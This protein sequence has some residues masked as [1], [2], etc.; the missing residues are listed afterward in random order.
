VS[1]NADPQNSHESKSGPTETTAVDCKPEDYDSEGPSETVLKRREE[2][3]ALQARAKQRREDYDRI[4]GPLPVRASP[5]REYP[6]EEG[7]IK[8]NRQ[9]KRR[10]AMLMLLNA[11][12]AAFDS[13]NN[14]GGAHISLIHA[15]MT[16]TTLTNQVP[17]LPTKSYRMPHQMMVIGSDRECSSPTSDI[18]NSSQV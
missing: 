15:S 9:P 17:Q 8:W 5:P 18:A 10:A 2:F 16:T 12:R 14:R 11:A 3:R 6:P 13:F 1:R 4:Y 7:G